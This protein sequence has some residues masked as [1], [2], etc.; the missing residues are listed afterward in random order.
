M[1]LAIAIAKSFLCKVFNGDHFILKGQTLSKSFSAAKSLGFKHLLSHLQASVDGIEWNARRFLLLQP[2]HFRLDLER[3]V[4]EA[5]RS[6]DLLRLLCESLLES[7][8]F[9]LP[10]VLLVP[11]FSLLPSHDCC[12]LET[13]TAPLIRVRPPAAAVFVFHNSSEN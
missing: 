12:Q 4:L 5:D 10:L 3:F 9:F 6:P 7:F 1:D 2:F 11:A 13:V 8:S